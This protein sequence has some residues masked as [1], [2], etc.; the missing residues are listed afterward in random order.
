MQKPRAT[1]SLPNPN[2]F[3]LRLSLV[4]SFDSAAPSPNFPSNPVLY[5]SHFLIR[6]FQPAS[7][8]LR[9]LSSQ[10]MWYSWYQAYIGQASSKHLQSHYYLR[11]QGLLLSLPVSLRQLA[12]CAATSWDG[13]LQAVSISN[14]PIYTFSPCFSL[15]PRPWLDKYRSIPLLILFLFLLIPFPSLHFNCFIFGFFFSSSQPFPVAGRL[16]TPTTN[17]LFTKSF[18]DNQTHRNH[19]ILNRRS[20]VPRGCCHC[21][22]CCYP[23]TPRWYVFSIHV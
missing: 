2:C 4:S 9:R 14:E 3:S 11:C 13:T 1:A 19:A 17:P 23:S 16:F 8:Q 21:R 6:L 10:F 15:L 18:P 12:T 22:P 5:P 7:C 20:L